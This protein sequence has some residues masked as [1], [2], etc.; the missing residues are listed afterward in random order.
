ML[1]LAVSH[2]FATHGTVTV[3]TIRIR[4]VVVFVVFAA[5]SLQLL[6]RLLVFGLCRLL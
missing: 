5:L 3:I 1:V 2:V 4:V 6:F